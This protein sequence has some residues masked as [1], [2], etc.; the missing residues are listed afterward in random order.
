MLK[1]N[2]RWCR[3]D[4]EDD[5]MSI[6]QVYNFD[7][8]VVKYFVVPDKGNSYMAKEDWI[9]TNYKEHKGSA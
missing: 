3:K 6:G 5:R 7:E 4:D 1:Y 2:S 8:A 9:R